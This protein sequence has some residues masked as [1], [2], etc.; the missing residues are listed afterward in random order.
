MQ[1][2]ILLS[3]WGRPEMMMMMMMMMMMLSEGEP[4]LPQ[5]CWLSIRK[6]IPPVK[7]LTSAISI[8]NKTP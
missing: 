8:P 1:V 3:K 4:S 6:F 5:H 2:A 7:H